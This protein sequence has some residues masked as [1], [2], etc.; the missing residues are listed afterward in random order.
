MIIQPAERYLN[1]IIVDSKNQADVIS[2]KVNF[3]NFSSTAKTEANLSEEDIDLGWNT[4]NEL[5]DEIVDIVFNLKK[6]TVSK[7]L[8]SSFGWH[9]IKVAGKDIIPAPDLEAMRAQLSNNLSTQTL[10]RLLEQLRASHDIQL[11]SF[12]DVRKDAMNAN[13]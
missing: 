2:S 12:A 13:Q 11:R 9:I 10:G 5:P 6:G 3:N 7:P 8:E 1:Q 4:K